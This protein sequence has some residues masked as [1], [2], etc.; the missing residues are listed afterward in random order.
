MNTIVAELGQAEINKSLRDV[1]D[2]QRASFLQDM[3]VSLEVRRDR[4]ERGLAMILLH[5]GNLVDA[6]M[7]D[8]PTRTR[9]WTLIA[10]IFSTVQVY[11]GA[12]K[13][14]HR[15]MR[16]QRRGAPP[17]F[18]LFGARAEIQYQPL[19]VVGV[20]GAWNAP[21]N[22]VLVP[23]A[24][25]LAAGNRAMLCPSD[26]MTA[27]AA[28]LN[29]AVKEYFDETE[30]TVISG[31]LEV[32]KAFSALP[33]DHLLFTGS[34]GV[35]AQVMAA[36]APNLV[37]VTLELGGKC[38]VVITPD[39]DM[40]DAVKRLIAAKTLNG[41]QACLA[42]DHFF[43]PRNQ[44]DSFIKQMDAA[45]AELYP[46]SVANEAY[47]GL[48]TDRHFKRLV[49]VVAQARDQGTRIEVIGMQGN[50]MNESDS[51]KRRLAMHLLIDPPAGTR[52]ANEELFGPVIVVS[53]YDDLSEACVRIRSA[54]KPL[55]IYVFSKNAAQRQFVLDR[56][57]SGGITLN[58]AMM[59]YSVPDLPF[60][61]VG[62]S[63][64]GAYSFGV[65]GFRCF[66]HARAVYKQAGPRSL[67]RV[68]QPPYGGMFNWVIKGQLQKLSKRYGV[69]RKHVYT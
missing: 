45:M 23:L 35:G 2:R 55:A 59:H 63:G 65:E 43:V 17:P 16:P 41:G 3:P 24:T 12:I 53:T 62:R 13:N 21:I 46:G 30:V 26:M 68:V 57:F 20:M 25:V 51:V 36:A 56:T 58:D 19:G 66:S 31:G 18:N 44:L 15:W 50:R 67:M 9:E 7:Q 60:G 32:S 34:P 64:I 33:F 52:A 29:T 38:P 14:V 11:T 22:G 69:K 6:L 40:D 42:P 39:A 27:T 28:A 47:C 8:F 48:A 4:I 37:P 1:L 10:E 49:D 54:P 61:G 5:R